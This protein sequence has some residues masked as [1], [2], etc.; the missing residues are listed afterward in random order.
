MA[1]KRNQP[2]GQPTAGATALAAAAIAA[3]SA[4][5]PAAAA[6]GG[7]AGAGALAAG[8]T[9]VASA[10]VASVTAAMRRLARRRRVLIREAA[11]A[12][13]QKESDIEKALR[14]EDAYED[15]FRKRSAGRLRTAVGIGVKAPD[16]SARQAALESAVRREQ[17]YSRQ[18][19]MAAGERVFAA[20]DREVL[21]E[22]S[23]QGAFWIL[24]PTVE[25]TPD[26]VA[27]N[28]KFWP[29]AVLERLAPPLHVGCKC[30][31]LSYGEAL[32]SGRMGAGG[33]PSEAEAM[34]LAAP[35]LSYVEK[36]HGHELAIAEELELREALVKHPGTDRNMLAA[37]PYRADSIEIADFELDLLNEYRSHVGG[38]IRDDGTRVKPFWRELVGALKDLGDP[39][40][41]R[42]RIDVKVPDNHTIKSVPNEPDSFSIKGPDGKERKVKGAAVVAAAVGTPQPSVVRDTLASTGRG[43]D[44]KTKERTGPK[45]PRQAKIE[46]RLNQIGEANAANFEARK[47][48]F[49]QKSIADAKAGNTGFD[50]KHSTHREY[51]NGLEAGKGLEFHDPPRMEYHAEISAALVNET[52]AI[53][54]GKEKRAVFLFG[55]PAGGKGGIKRGGESELLHEDD[56]FMDIDPDRIGKETNPEFNA[57]TAENRKLLEAGSDVDLTPAARVHEESSQI[58]KDTL[59]AAIAG[60]RAFTMDGLGMKAKWWDGIVKAKDEHGYSPTAAG[61]TISFEAAQERALKRSKKPPYR[62][63]DPPVVEDGHKQVAKGFLPFLE[64]ADEHDLPVELWDNETSM[65]LIAR[66]RPGDKQIQI[67]NQAKFDLFLSRA[68]GPEGQALEIQRQL[69]EPGVARPLPRIEG[70][71]GKMK[72]FP[73]DLLASG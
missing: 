8:N 65:E 59:A 16:T 50:V 63:V 33:V 68:D 5:P 26:C 69:D 1:Q 19:A 14:L 64:I 51:G 10:I 18:R 37:L 12:A 29:W 61:V 32:S 44:K 2:T 20:I 66:R 31:L 53:P 28:G 38:Y 30:R 60:D 70:P 42:T 71:D 23:P 15:E 3:G 67:L 41:T 39:S 27:L 40:H 47:V 9:A 22:E 73:A 58:A 46:T 4:A 48:V 21:R 34:S 43:F 45:E 17:N 6:G 13:G 11:L 72:D 62:T 56:N 24:G 36:H 35:I 57:L 54:E 55:G 7:A 25:H 52:D 49:L